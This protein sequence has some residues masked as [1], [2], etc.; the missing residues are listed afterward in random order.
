MKR[1]RKLSRRIKKRRILTL[2]F[3]ITLIIFGTVIFKAV[4]DVKAN[5]DLQ[6]ASAKT[7]EQSVEDND[8]KKEEKKQEEEQKQK[9]EDKTAI[10]KGKNYSQIGQAYVD[11]PAKVQEIIKTG[12]NEGKKVAYL[13]F[14][15]G[16][17]VANTTKILDTLKEKDVKA[18]FFIMGQ[19]ITSSKDADVIKREVAEGHAIANHTFSHNYK[20]LYP[21][22]VVDVN[23]FM[24]DVDKANNKLKEVLGDDFHTNVVRMPGGHM[25]WHGTDKLDKVFAEK[26]YYYIDWNAVNGDAEGKANKTPAELFEYFKNSSGDK[27]ALVVLM[28]DTQGKKHT[29]EALPEIIDYLKNKG[30]EFRTIG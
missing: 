13:T 24:E 17:S 20:K 7:N 5:K 6:Q 19:E 29:V 1:N 15:D 12:K 22:R 26:Q 9:K 27:E 30:Y 2:L 4:F 3:A 11:D 16:P 8:K 18:T 28:H 23:T 10:I 14:D 25:S 21:K